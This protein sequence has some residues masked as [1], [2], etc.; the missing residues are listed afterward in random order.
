MSKLSILSVHKHGSY[1]F[2]MHNTLNLFY[3]A[4]A[5]LATAGAFLLGIVTGLCA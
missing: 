2:T 1:S 4:L 5:T 3:L